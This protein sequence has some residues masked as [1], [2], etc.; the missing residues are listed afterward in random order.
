MSKDLGH[1]PKKKL[2][3]FPEKSPPTKGKGHEF[4]IKAG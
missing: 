1:P 3:I 2:R 4:P